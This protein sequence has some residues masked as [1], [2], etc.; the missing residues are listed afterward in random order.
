MMIPDII[1]Y[2][3]YFKNKDMREEGLL[4]QRNE[5]ITPV[6]DEGGHSGIMRQ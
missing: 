3:R 4:F 5:E 6:E 2:I 1:Q